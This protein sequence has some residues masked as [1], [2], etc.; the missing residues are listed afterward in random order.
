MFWVQGL[1]IFFL[2]RHL[3]LKNAIE[4]VK[5]DRIIAVTIKADSFLR[6]IGFENPRI[7]VAALNPHASDG[8]LIGDEEE[9]EII[10]AIKEIRARAINAVGPIAADSVFQQAFSGK[11]DAVL[12]LYHDQGHIPAKTIDFHGTVSVTLGLPFVRTSV[13]HGTAFDI[14][15]KG[16]ANS[17]SLEEA[18]RSAA[19]F[20]QKLKVG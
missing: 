5:K 3:P 2:T 12:S 15:G 19:E 17:K 7:A 4:A 16:I 9:K 13:D 10:P 14:A 8:G 6:K 11:Y 20:A 18:I 1:A